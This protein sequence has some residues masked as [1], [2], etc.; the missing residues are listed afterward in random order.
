MPRTA[1]IIPYATWILLPNWRENIRKAI[2]FLVSSPMV[3]VGV[4][5]TTLSIMNL[6]EK[7]LGHSFYHFVTDVVQTYRK[8]F[9]YPFHLLDR[10][11]HVHIGD[12]Y[13]DIIVIW[14]CVAAIYARSYIYLTKASSELFKDDRSKY[15][16]KTEHRR[17]NYTNLQW[18]YKLSG[19]RL[20]LFRFLNH[21]FVW[22][23][24][25][26]DF[27]HP[28]SPFLY[29]VYVF[30]WVLPF[31]PLLFLFTAFFDDMMISVTWWMVR[32]GKRLD[33]DDPTYEHFSQ[34][35]A[36][37][38]EEFKVEVSLRSFF[39]VQ[40]LFLLSAIVLSTAY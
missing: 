12:P 20:R 33:Y 3:G 19:F 29:E 15:D 24:N 7:Y 10:F 32:D 18:G 35:D 25:A 23:T 11:L 21:R 27:T 2:L 30:F 16:S 22:W 34:E 13:R 8:I 17:V 5:A 40:L 28:K 36:D 37:T 26:L 6:L 38:E 39:W 14:L 1:R 9:F 4:V 31:A